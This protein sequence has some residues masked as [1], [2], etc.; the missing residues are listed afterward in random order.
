M[1]SKESQSALT[2]E[3]ALETLREENLRFVQNLT[4]NRN[5]VSKLMRPV[6]PSFLLQ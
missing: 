1:R 6:T 2:P 5:C 4:L 3:K